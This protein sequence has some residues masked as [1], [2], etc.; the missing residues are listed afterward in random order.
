MV[1]NFIILLS[2]HILFLSKRFS[3]L[4]S[5]QVNLKNFALI[6][7]SPDLKRSPEGCPHR[8]PSWTSLHNSLRYGYEGPSTAMFYIFVPEGTDHTAHMYVVL[9]CH[10]KMSCSTIHIDTLNYLLGMLAPG[11]VIILASKPVLSSLAL[12]CSDVHHVMCKPLLPWLSSI[13]W[14]RNFT[15]YSELYHASITIIYDPC[16]P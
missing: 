10:R 5:R 3:S 12:S 13:R 7:I 4:V 2:G 9:W 8:Q 14:M 15:S 6:I 11:F 16:L 1:L